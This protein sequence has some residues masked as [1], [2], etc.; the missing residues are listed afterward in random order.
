M[1]CG[2]PICPGHGATYS[3]PV[4]T[5]RGFAVLAAALLAAGCAGGGGR[6]PPS[7]GGAASS[8]PSRTASASAPTPGPQPAGGTGGGRPATGA[9]PCGTAA[10]A[11]RWE[12]VVWVWLENHGPDALTQMPYLASVAQA[13][14]ITTDYRGITH[15]SL[16]NY[17]AAVSGSTGGVTSDCSPGECPQRRR[18]IFA[19]VSAAGGQWRA[20]EE[21]MPHSCAASATS[22]YAPKHNPPVYFPDLAADCARWD[23]P[24]APALT[25]DLAAGRLPR[26]AFVTPDICHDAHDCPVGAAD[27]WLRT[28]LARI[29]AGPDYRTGRTAVVVTFDEDDNGAGNRVST[30]VVAP[31][32]RP[33][34]R[35]GTAFS[36]YSLLRTTE[37]MLGLP[38]LG[39]AASAPSMRAAFGL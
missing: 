21:A 27:T 36:H 39:A 12:H 34:T 8:A 31:T 7:A 3:W 6:T 16:P 30:V 26:F 35:S 15:P 19:Q 23:V 38:L 22:S 5:V 1:R 4:I 2:L 9:G 13:C 20:Y 37:E 24:L 10:T 17:L 32:V 28:W 18:T 33:G 14:G 25:D 11:P 29:L